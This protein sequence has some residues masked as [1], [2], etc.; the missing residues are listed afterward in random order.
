MVTPPEIGE[1][2]ILKED[3][4]LSSLSSLSSPESCVVKTRDESFQPNFKLL[5]NQISNKKS[6]PLSDRVLRSQPTTT[7]PSTTATCTVTATTV[8]VSKS[9]TTTTPV[10]KSAATLIKPSYKQP[11]KKTITSLVA[12]TSK[13]PDYLDFD[14]N[15]Q[16]LVN[17]QSTRIAPPSNPVRPALTPFVEPQANSVY[18]ILLLLSWFYYSSN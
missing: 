8:S 12:S 7:G 14:E 18:G 15:D 13:E 1:A 10:Q 5:V 4:R 2:L 9:A 6:I 16:S 11:D 17:L 3:N